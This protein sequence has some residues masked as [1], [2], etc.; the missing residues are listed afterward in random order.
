MCGV[1]YLTMFS[2]IDKFFGYLY[3]IKR[4]L[5]PCPHGRQQLSECM[6]RKTVEWAMVPRK[7]LPHARLSR[8]RDH[9]IVW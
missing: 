6:I 9:L 8:E 2:T 1:Y 4:L 5:Y 3:T 7:V